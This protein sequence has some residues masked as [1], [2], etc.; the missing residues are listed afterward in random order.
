MKH[1][2]TL[3]FCLF[4][5]APVLFA[6]NTE[7]MADQL[8]DKLKS[9]VLDIGLLFQTDGYFSFDDD[10]FLGG[11]GYGLGA[12]RVRM[13][14]MVD[15]QFFYKVQVD[16]RRPVTLLDAQ[17]GYQFS[18]QMAL[19]TGA[20][21]PFLSIDLDPNPGATDFIN[22]ARHVGVMMN[23]REIG[24]SLL[25]DANSGLYYRL[26]MYN[27]TGLSLSNDNRFMY[28]GRLGHKTDS[29]ESS[30]HF[31]VQAAINQTE[32]E[33]VGN[34]GLVSEGD[35]TLFGG[36]VE[37]EST[38]FFGT[39]EFMQTRFDAINFGGTE[40]NITGFFGTIGA[41]VSEK[42]QL[43]AR[44][45]YIGYDIRDYNS[46]QFILGWNHQATSLISFQL[47]F[48]AQYDNDEDGQYGLLGVFQFQI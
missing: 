22:R 27:G 28:T 38:T 25:G 3:T 10:D 42:D 7:P 14:G 46:D 40:E 44:W 4:L 13:Q 19:V 20:F 29:D 5:S 30:I 39:A 41:N 24:L 16:L 32:Q 43:L 31:G 23:T 1:I 21:K 33:R 18:D 34:S 17:L 35:R 8:R 9:E 11:R 2:L 26:G 47:N 6:Q 37:F 12:T 15:N 45:D 48:V 36:F